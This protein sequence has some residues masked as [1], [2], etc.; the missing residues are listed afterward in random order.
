MVSRALCAPSKQPLHKPP[1]NSQLDWKRSPR[2]LHVPGKKLLPPQQQ[3]QTYYYSLNM[4][5]SGLIVSCPTFFKAPKTFRSSYITHIP[6]PTGSVH[7][8]FWS[9]IIPLPDFSRTQDQ[10]STKTLH[11]KLFDYSLQL[12]ASYI[13]LQFTVLLTSIPSYHRA[14]RW[15][16]C[17]PYSS[18]PFL[19][20]FPLK[21]LPTTPSCC[22]HLLIPALLPSISRRF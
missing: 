5:S 2:I 22:S 17:P 11:W 16:R 7:L 20:R 14:W 3:S 6:C 10:S 21:I 19:P 4:R 9:P 18:L 8:L 15:R 13:P 12:H 1:L